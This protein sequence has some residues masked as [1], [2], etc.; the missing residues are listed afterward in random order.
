[1]SKH[2]LPPA[3]FLVFLL[4]ALAAA[5]PDDAAAEPFEAFG[6][7]LA[8]P[9]AGLPAPDPELPSPSEAPSP[10]T[11]LPAASPLPSAS[12]S[13]AAASP[14]AG[15][16]AEAGAAA[17]AAAAEAT[18]AARAAYEARAA[19]L[20]AKVAELELALR[21]AE[22]A[23][24]ALPEG[25]VELE[26][27][28]AELEAERDGLAGRLAAERAGRLDLEPYDELLL[29]GFGSARPRI[30]TWKVEG[31]RASQLDAKAFFARLEMPLEQTK[32]PYL[33]RF[34]ARS[35]GQGWVGLGLHLFASNVRSRKG[36]GEGRSLLVWLTRDP[37]ERR[38]DATYLQLYRSDDDVNM[39]RVLDAKLE[40]R[41][42]DRNLVEVLYDPETGYL[43]VALNGRLAAKYRTWFGIEG[44]IGVSLRSLG[45]GASFSGFEVLAAR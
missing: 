21:E 4:S 15:A 39:E 19:E 10:A 1:M 3:A 14:Q 34:T 35:E 8:P 33:Y 20:E 27:R 2:R 32:R 23:G 7:R 30:G 12:D 6:L 36:Y 26:R 41:I 38:I 45:G 16:E 43:A 28:I 13:Q 22:E 40:E 29:S 24:Q 17:T 25:A 5:F 37:E 42:S 44:G 9:E 18:E 11:A 31:G